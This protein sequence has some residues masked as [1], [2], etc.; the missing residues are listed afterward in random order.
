MNKACFLDRDGVVNEEVD[1]LSDPDKAIIITGSAQAIKKLRQHGYLAIVVSNQAGV[2][3]GLYRVEDVHKVNE[4]IQD[5]LNKEGAMID[6]YYFC[7]HHPEFSGAC[8]CRK[9]EPGMLLQAAKKYA[10]DLTQSFM[11]GDRI[12]DLEAAQRAGCKNCY[13]VRTGYGAEVI[14]SQNPAGVKISDNL[15]A[16]VDDFFDHLPDCSN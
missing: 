4:R 1:Y 5:L 8:K 10:I 15:A 2:A 6:E 16:A 13:L 14:K 12:S 7:P 9:P 3:R 11:V